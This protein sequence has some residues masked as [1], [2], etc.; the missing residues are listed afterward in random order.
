MITS[1]LFSL[2]MATLP[3][4]D[5]PHLAKPAPIQE[6]TIL[7]YVVIKGICVPICEKEGYE[8]GGRIQFNMRTQYLTCVC[9]KKDGK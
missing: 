8:W 3:V 4:A 2:V 1:L 6:Q 5:P 9:E 7:D